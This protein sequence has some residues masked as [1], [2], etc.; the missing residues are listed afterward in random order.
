MGSTVRYSPLQFAR[1]NLAL[2][3]PPFQQQ[4]VGD[5]GLEVRV[6]KFADVIAGRESAAQDKIEEK[7]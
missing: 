4:L 7:C 6:K 5:A 3:R 2:G 1:N